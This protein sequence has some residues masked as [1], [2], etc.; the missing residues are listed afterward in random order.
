[1]YYRDH[2]PPHF[3]AIYGQY[4]A[5]IGIASAQILEGY[6]PRHALSLVIEWARTFRHELEEDWERA[7]AH[8]PL[9]PIPP[10]E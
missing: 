7:R 6:L 8:R 3:H 4:E 10:L 2:G 1:M 5:T 9:Q